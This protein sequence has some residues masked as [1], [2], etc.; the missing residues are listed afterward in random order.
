VRVLSEHGRPSGS[1][2]RCEWPC[3]ICS[4]GIPNKPAPLFNLFLGGGVGVGGRGD[5]SRETCFGGLVFQVLI[6]YLLFLFFLHQQ[7]NIIFDFIKLSRNKYSL[8]LSEELCVKDAG[9]LFCV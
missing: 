1:S 8:P 7:M 9:D 5:G 2:G 6:F 4:L 3:L